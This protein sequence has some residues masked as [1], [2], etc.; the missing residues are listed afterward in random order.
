MLSNFTVSM[1]PC[2]TSVYSITTF[3]HCFNQFSETSLKLILKLFL[4]PSQICQDFVSSVRISIPTKIWEHTKTTTPLVFYLEPCH[5]STFQRLNS[6]CGSRRQNP[7]TDD[8]R[9]RVTPIAF[10]KLNDYRF[11]EGFSALRTNEHVLQAAATTLPIA[12]RSSSRSCSCNFRIWAAV[13]T[14]S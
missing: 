1:I 12:S 9:Q 11:A 14:C 4:R 2:S 13:C 7:H 3:K 10:H 8:F 5:S 6:A